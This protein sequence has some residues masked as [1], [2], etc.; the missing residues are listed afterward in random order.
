MRY[1]IAVLFSCALFS[2]IFII[3]RVGSLVFQLFVVYN[4]KLQFAAI[5]LY[6]NHMSIRQV[7]EHSGYTHRA[8]TRIQLTTIG[9]NY[10]C[11][12]RIDR[13]R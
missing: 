12:N 13:E 2:V 4:L 9:N 1:C 10:I 7:T 11:H 3:G 8:K 6:E 5:W